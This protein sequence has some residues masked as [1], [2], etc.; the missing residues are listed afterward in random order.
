MLSR[1]G[2]SEL[3]S[4]TVVER[5]AR[6]S[7]ALVVN[8][9]HHGYPDLLLRGQ[10]PRD[11]IS[12][13]RAALKLKRAAVPLDGRATVRVQVGSLWFSFSSTSARMSPLKTLSL[14]AWSRY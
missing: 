4:R 10:Y 5:L 12:E 13:E 3:I 2:F 8:Q 14:R 1:A 11:A 6:A 7:R 9:Y